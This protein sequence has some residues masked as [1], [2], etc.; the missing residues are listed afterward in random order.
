MGISDIWSRRFHQ[1]AGRTKNWVFYISRPTLELL[2]K[3]GSEGRNAYHAVKMAVE[4]FL[5]KQPDANAFN[6][7]NSFSINTSTFDVE[8]TEMYCTLSF[9]FDIRDEITNKLGV[10][11]HAA[12]ANQ[13]EGKKVKLSHGD[14]FPSMFDKDFTERLRKELVKLPNNTT[15]N[16][17]HNTTGKTPHPPG[18]QDADPMWFEYASSKMLPTDQLLAKDIEFG[19][20]RNIV[21]HQYIEIRLHKTRSKDK[22]SSREQL[23]ALQRFDSFSSGLTNF[24]GPPGTGKSTLLHMVCAHRLFQNFREQLEEE[25]NKVPVKERTRKTTILYYLH[26][27]TLRD[28]AIREVKSILK[29]VYLPLYPNELKDEFG[30]RLDNVMKEGIFYINQEELISSNITPNPDRNIL[31][32]NS[33]KE[34]E[35]QKFLKN[36]PAP[37]PIIRRGL[38]NIV[39]GMFGNYD[40]YNQW[41]REVGDWEKHA[42]NFHRPNSGRI[43][44]NHTLVMKD[45]LPD[46]PNSPIKKQREEFDKQV[47]KLS[48]ENLLWDGTSDEQFWDPSCLFYLSSKEFELQGKNS[49]WQKLEHRVDWIVIDEVQDTSLL[50]IRILLDHFSNRK[51]GH[52]YRDFRLIIAGDENQ[53]VNHLLYQPQN[54][55]I[56]YTYQNWVQRLK[57]TGER[58]LESYR[59]SQHLT[60]EISVLLKSGYRVFD[61]MLPFANDILKSLREHH[62]KTNQKRQKEAKLTETNYGRNGVF[63]RLNNNLNSTQKGYLDKWQEQML[64]QLEKQMLT[65]VDEEQAFEPDSSE[66]IRVAFTYD[67]V[68]FDND[69]KTDESPF[70]KRL[71]IDGSYINDFAEKVDELMK[72]FAKKFETWYANDNTNNKNSMV[73]EMAQA[74]QLRGV[75]DVSSIKGLTMPVCLILP[76]SRLTKGAK[77]E[78]MEDLSKFLVQITRA[79]YFNIIIE[80]TRSFSEQLTDKAIVM[81]HEWPIENVGEWLEAVLNHSAGFDH[82][83]NRIFHSTMNRYDSKLLWTRLKKDSEGIDENLSILVDWLHDLLW[84]FKHDDDWDPFE[85]EKDHYILEALL[86]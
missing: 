50:E 60:D 65:T 18:V 19:K 13:T 17:P 24:S 49:Y 69:Y 15:E 23:D 59:L 68:D 61:E 14:N 10:V 57:E 20:F 81:S 44:Q 29:E 31:S 36:R 56:E 16:H 22:S 37:L 54:R 5:D 75:M 76:S 26:S 42:V 86:F 2:R 38:R 52:P 85:W 47:K 77:Q 43:A 46:E 9:P 79:Q 62:A 3:P 48:E 84:A 78:T 58:T 28:E 80:D 35:K 4:A 7:S 74:L 64:T 45:F 8:H 70:T 34:L 11:I 67:S 53:N 30:D 41:V 55:H 27:Q 21:A 39:F 66:P 6:V 32:D 72:A 25:M 73:S 40:K 1:E 82:T 51:N 12:E 83:F 71:K 63:V 33:K